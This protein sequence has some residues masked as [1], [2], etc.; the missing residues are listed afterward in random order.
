[1]FYELIR[2]DKKIFN[3]LIN[4]IMHINGFHLLQLSLFFLF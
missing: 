1:M 2:E 3:L 4:R